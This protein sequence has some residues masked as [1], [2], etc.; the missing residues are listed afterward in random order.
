MQGEPLARLD[1]LAI[2]FGAAQVKLL[3]RG[4]FDPVTFIAIFAGQ[5]IAGKK[6]VIC[7]ELPGARGPP[8]GVK[9]IPLVEP[10]I[11]QLAVA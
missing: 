8:D 3:P 5:V 9:V 6:T 2:K 11:A 4:P 1:G 10:L 7:T